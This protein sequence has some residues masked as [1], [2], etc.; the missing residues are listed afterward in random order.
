MT[1][2]L[3][4]ITG[5]AGSGKDTLADAIVL[6]FGAVKYNFAL[7]LKEGLN[8]IMGWS[9]EMWNDRVWKEREIRWLG[10]SPR[11]CA[12]TLGTEWGREEVHPELWVMLA[13]HRFELHSQTSKVPF[14]IA[15]VRFD[16]EARAIRRQGGVVIKVI[17]PDANPISEHVSEKG[18]SDEHIDHVLVNDTSLQRYLERALPVLAHWTEFA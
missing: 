2:R 14:V 9:M 8:A 12:Q 11:Q 16:N 17:R 13:L 15:D 3:I 10:K 5:K 18:V 6:E 7:P 1:P 4:G